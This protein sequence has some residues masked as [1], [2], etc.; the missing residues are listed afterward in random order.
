MKKIT[1]LFLLLSIVSFAQKKEKV[2]GSKKVSL[3][4]R[5]VGE[6]EAVE[7]ADDLQVFLVKGDKCSIE[8]EADDNIHD[9]L[10]VN[11]LGK[12][13]QLNMAKSLGS[14]KK[15]QVRIN[16]T[17]NFKTVVSRNESVITALATIDLDEITFKSFDESKLFLNVKTKNFTLRADDKSKSELNIKS[18]NTILEL[19][20]S[21]LTKSLISSGN[22]KVDLYQKSEAELEGDANEMKLRLDNN[23]NFVGKK[24]VAKTMD[25]SIEGYS[26]SKINVSQNLSIL[27]SGNAEIEL[28]GDQKIDMKKFVD[29]SKLTKKPTR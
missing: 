6:F 29:N 24:L 27:S 21:A 5:E 13:L 14:Y 25:L 9:A 3:E 15:F 16:Y 4:V 26:N 12:T 20:K 22:L 8:I 7:I 23:T 1:V 17:S 2:K 18:E 28:Y 19:S 10:G 11:L